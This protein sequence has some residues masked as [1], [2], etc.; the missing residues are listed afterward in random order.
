[1]KGSTTI[2]DLNAYALKYLNKDKVTPEEYFINACV[3]EL[4]ELEHI[5]TSKKLFRKTLDAKDERAY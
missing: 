1:M 3:E 4:F 5:C 2:V